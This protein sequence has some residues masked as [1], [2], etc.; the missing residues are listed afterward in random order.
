MVD[1]VVESQ[2]NGFA[3]AFLAVFGVIALALRSVKI[4]A[5]AVPS[6]LLP[7]FLILGVM[8]ASGIRLD[9]ATVTIA[10][11]VLGL[12]VDDT[13]HFL[14][15]LREELERHADRAAALR[16][17]VASAGHAIMTTALVMTLGFAVFALSEIRSLVYFGLLIALAMATSVLTDLLFIPALVML[18]PSKAPRGDGVLEEAS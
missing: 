10:S 8:G 11:V 16:E 18:R 17:T 1:Y 2:I 15:R 3:T 4:A 14:Y 5:L 6:N 12:V 9:A 7:L 13:V